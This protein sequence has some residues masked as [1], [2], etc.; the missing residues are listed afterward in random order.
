MR[1]VRPADNP[2][3]SHRIDALAFRARGF[4]PSELPVRLRRLGGRAAIVGREG[5]GKTTL[6]E[7]LANHLLDQAIVVRLPGSCPQPWAT[8]RDQLPNDLQAG[9]TVLVDGGEQLGTSGWRRLLQRTSPAGGLIATLHRP[10]RL[11]ILVECRTDL[12][13][14]RELVA[15]LAPAVATELAP[16]LPELFERHA[17]NLRLCFRELYD[18]CGGRIQAGGE[19]RRS[20]G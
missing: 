16:L 6:L 7:E 20:P 13:L 14:L 17:G 18:V 19:N 9:H 11:P 8:A 5:S 1:A 3:A 10:G 2:F 12:E 4:H 15:A